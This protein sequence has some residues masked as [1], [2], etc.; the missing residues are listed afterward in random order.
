MI[1]SEEQLILISDYASNF[2]NW[3]Q[4]AVLMDIDEEDFREQMLD[5]SSSV[6]KTY[7]KGKTKS[8]YDLNKKLVSLAKLGSPQA[9]LLVRS[10]IERQLNEE[11]EL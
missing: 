8:T 7:T 10:D 3:K 1:L 4:I 5:K 6:F 9:E 11:N 2:M